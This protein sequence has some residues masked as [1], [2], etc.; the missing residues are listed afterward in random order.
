MT[1]KDYAQ[2]AAAVNDARE[3]L[4]ARAEKTEPDQL[5]RQIEQSP[6]SAAIAAVAGSL[7]DTLAEHNPR[8]DR[9][10]FVNACFGV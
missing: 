5:L 8:F 6:N 1:R 7:A 3:R 2:I 4:H 9:Q 10:K